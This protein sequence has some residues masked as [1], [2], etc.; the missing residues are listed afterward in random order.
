MVNLGNL[1]MLE[2]DFDTAESWY[3]RVLQLDP[4]NRAAENGLNR[5]A[6]DRLE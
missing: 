6:V 3:R 4:D 1:A 2:N 5:I